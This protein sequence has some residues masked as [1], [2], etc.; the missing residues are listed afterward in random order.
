MSYATAYQPETPHDEAA[1][2][3]A[4]KAITAAGLREFPYPFRGSLA[5]VSDIDSA[6][7]LH[8][9]RY[10]NILVKCNGLDF[11]DSVWLSSA[12]RSRAG[13]AFFDAALGIDQPLPHQL[14]DASPSFYEVL[15][16]FYR[17]D[18]DHFHS[19]LSS[20]PRALICS[21]VACS[22]N[23]TTAKP[24][25]ATNR[26][27]WPYSVDANFFVW[28]LLVCAH[29]DYRLPDTITLV[30][31]PGRDSAAAKH[32]YVRATNRKTFPLLSAQHDGERCHLYLYPHTDAMDTPPPSALSVEHVVISCGAEDHETSVISSVLLLNTHTDILFRRLDLLYDRFHVSA[33]LVTTHTGWHFTAPKGLQTER[34][35]LV[36]QRMATDPCA[37]ESRWGVF[38]KPGLHFSTLADDPLSFCRLFPEMVDR[39]GIRCIVPYPFTC[40]RNAQFTLHDFLYPSR[41]CTE[42]PLYVFRR[43]LFNIP[44]AEQA[45]L[46]SH[47]V[48]NSHAS[49]FSARI[50]ALLSTAE[51]NPGKVWPVY[52]HLGHIGPL[53]T[54]PDPYLEP[55]SIHRLRAAHFGLGSASGFSRLWVTRPST[56]CDYRIVLDGLPQAIE[57]PDQDTIVVRSWINPHL[58]QRLPFSIYQLYGATFYVGSAVSSSVTLDGIPVFDLVRN[59]ADET[60]VQSVMI[61]ACPIRHVVFDECN[62]A[63]D[64]HGNLGNVILSANSAF[65]WCGSDN[66]LAYSGRH[67][68]RLGIVNCRDSRGAEPTDDL[69][70]MPIAKARF[71]HQLLKPCGCQ[72]FYYALQRTCSS[73]YFGILLETQSEGRFYFGDPELLKHIDS[74]NAS[75][76]PTRQT[77]SMLGWERIVIPLYDLTWHDA[78]GRLDDP[79]LPTHATRSITYILM[80]PRDSHVWI[81]CVEFGRPRTTLLPRQL[82]TYVLGGRVTD[83]MPKT[84][85]CVESVTSP[86]VQQSVTVPVHAG[87]WFYCLCLTEGAYRLRVLPGDDSTHTASWTYAELRSDRL[88]LELPMITRTIQESG[89]NSQT[90]CPKETLMMTCDERMTDFETK[91]QPALRAWFEENPSLTDP[92]YRDKLSGHILS[93]LQIFFVRH[94]LA[95]VDVSRSV[96]EVGTGMGQLP[97]FLAAQG[98]E[99]YGLE[100]HDKRCQGM[101]FL[102]KALSNVYPRLNEHFHLVQGR[103]PDAVPPVDVLVFC[104]TV[105]PVFAELLEPILAVLRKF[106]QVILD[107]RTFGVYRNTDDE[108]NELCARISA[109][110]FRVETVIKGKGYHVV[111]A[112]RID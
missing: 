41:A 72:H 70:Q 3:A 36:V 28:G 83:A 53:S 33:N 26:A 47:V 109:V 1:I 86:S 21:N 13:V 6:C 112:H 57:R 59:P 88:D 85:V 74:V 32:I 38:D 56:L 80:S 62:P 102:C 104:N 8:V 5:I 22:A 110:G 69:P 9:E 50:H 94:I 58:R 60:G 44:E 2:E 35:Q 39:Y 91:A 64:S 43:T 82:D 75:Y 76:C 77:G 51:S 18:V 17:G 11:G 20:G 84:R 78:T 42:H 93:G 15:N 54:P 61:A 48:V 106:P 98:Y 96:C 55:G 12:R 30:T 97:L 23:S 52:T 81:D 89:L 107:L 73:Q 25:D 100:M 99:A 16:A 67:C 10:F 49:S 105:N 87:G 4:R 24:P 90:N 14:A 95:H 103:F 27:E 40:V 63:L 29:D 65:E 68:L 46:P 71:D 66:V 37:N 7:R 45:S 101:A 79:P 31:R 92:F 108:Q 19:F 34:Y 111:V